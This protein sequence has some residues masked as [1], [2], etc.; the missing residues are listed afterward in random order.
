MFSLKRQ[1]SFFS[2]FQ[3]DVKYF[4]SL[5]KNAERDA[6]ADNDSIIKQLKEN[7]HTFFFCSI[8]IEKSTGT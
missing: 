3:R 5:K 4:F 2:Y 6:L 7:M 8:E 1:N